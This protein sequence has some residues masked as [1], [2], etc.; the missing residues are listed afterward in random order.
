MFDL[1]ENGIK[2]KPNVVDDSIA[3][4]YSNELSTNFH[5]IKSIKKFATNL[6]D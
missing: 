3:K 6:N 2:L 1:T 4:K 5:L